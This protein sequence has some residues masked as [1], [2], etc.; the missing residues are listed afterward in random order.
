MGNTAVHSKERSTFPNPTQTISSRNHFKNEVI[1]LSSMIDT[2]RRCQASSVLESWCGQPEA[3][4][5]VPLEMLSVPCPGSS[6]C[7]R[8]PWI[9]CWSAYL[10]ATHRYLGCNASY[11]SV[12]L[13]K[14]SSALRYILENPRQ[15]D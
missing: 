8:K 12:S 10:P 15:W 13:T 1:S 9:S 14:V 7:P 6:H 2:P 5:V 4:N 11:D 3:G